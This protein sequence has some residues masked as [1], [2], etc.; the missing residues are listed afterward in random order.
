MAEEK[1]DIEESEDTLD[2]AEA[3]PE[4]VKFWEEKQ[5]ELVTSVVD[6][7]LS[8][9]AELLQTKTIDLSPRYQRRCRWDD[10]RQSKLIESFLMNVPVPPIFLNEDKYGKYSVIDGKQRLNAIFEFLRGRLRLTGLEVFHDINGKNFDN[11]PPDLQSVIKLRP[12][13]R[14]VIILRQSDDDIK[15]EVFR[16]LNTGGVRLNPQEIRNSAYPGP[17]N[18]LILDLSEHQSFHELLGI[19]NKEAS[20]IY[21]EMRDA[22]F[23]LRYFT[24]RDT[25]DTFTAGMRRC[26]DRFMLEN[27]RMPKK[28]REEVEQDFLSTVAVVRAA[29]GE[30]AFRR[31]VPEKGQWRRQVLASLYDAEMFACRAHSVGEVE[32]HQ[33]AIMKDMKAL[34]SDDDFRKS[35]DSATN[36]PASFRYR[37]SA[38][39]GV[40]QRALQDK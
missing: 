10:T 12:T 33:N 19:K 5:R 14:A 23:V 9:L 13:L 3:V 8:T 35:I 32:N 15:F 18:D 34:F 31:W 29:F 24:F 30:Y 25:W 40:L 17:L 1:R 37:I 20:A 11:L 36:A 2:E 4:E 16:R 22:E 21:Q 28:K 39:K 7:N 26:M 27:Q 6:Y 38:I